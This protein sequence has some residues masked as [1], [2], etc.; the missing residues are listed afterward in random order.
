MELL[1]YFHSRSYV[2]YDAA[3]PETIN[4]LRELLIL[5]KRVGDESP[6][7]KSSKKSAPE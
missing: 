4:A 6:L 3:A 7:A 1:K 2:G 5:K